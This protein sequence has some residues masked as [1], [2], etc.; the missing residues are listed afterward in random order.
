MSNLSNKSA[1]IG[2]QETPA[3]YPALVRVGEATNFKTQTWA[4]LSEGDAL[5]EIP[6]LGDYQYGERP[7]ITNSSALPHTVKSL[8][9]AG[10]H[11]STTTSAC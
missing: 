11:L 6:E 4:K 7:S 2:F 5:E 10:K 9:L 1:M 8:R 3:T